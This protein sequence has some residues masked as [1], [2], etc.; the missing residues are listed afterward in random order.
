MNR[1][2]SPLPNMFSRDNLFQNLEIYMF[3]LSYMNF[4]QHPQQ[5]NFSSVLDEN[6]AKGAEKLQQSRLQSIFFLG[7]NTF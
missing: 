7:E 1:H 6:S 4:K 2:D 5:R 3:F